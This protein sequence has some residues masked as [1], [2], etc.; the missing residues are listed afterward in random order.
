MFYKMSTLKFK[1]LPPM[2]K[3]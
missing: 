2:V 1:S 3:D